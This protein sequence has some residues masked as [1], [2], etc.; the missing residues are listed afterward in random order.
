MTALGDAALLRTYFACPGCG[1]GGAHVDG[2]LGL[3]NFLT[4]QAARLVC[5]AG[6][7][8][9]FAAAER[10]LEACCGWS[11]SDETIRHA[12]QAEARPIAAFRATAP[13]LGAAFAAAAGD[14]EFQVDA[15]K[16]HTTEG[17]RDMKI[18][19]FARRPRGEKATPEQWASRSLP[20]PTARAAFAA[21]E[22]IETFAP[23][24]GPWAARLGITE[25]AEI[26]VLG[27]GAAWI[28]NAASEQFPG[29]SQMLD[30]YH[31]AEHIGDAAK[32]LFGEGTPQ[33]ATWREGG[34]QLLLSDGWAGLCDHVGT[35]LAADSSLAGHD[36]LD[37]L[38]GYF[39]GQTGRLNY[40]HRLYTGQSI[41]S[42]MV[43][44]AAKNLIGRRLKQTGARWL[45]ANANAM[46]ELC[47]LSY[48][49]H[50]DLY[51]ASPN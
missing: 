2:L 5:L 4:R 38:I 16:V 47:C 17:W 32:G 7:Q 51:W 39:G 40:C 6:G 35:T 3:E 10:L 26:S 37:E 22:G 18:G 46:A 8:Y 1:Q 23:Q 34:R 29:C 36:A 50:W 11:V 24:W 25:M 9:A 13:T 28:W 20:P 27:D 33:A 12:C 19:I 15:T 41:G 45:V 14:I 21:I 43:E 31:A 49:D 44:G 42:G 48:S 30:I